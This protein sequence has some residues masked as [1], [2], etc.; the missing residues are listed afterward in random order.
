MKDKVF[1]DTN[2]VIYAYSTT[3]SNKQKTAKQ[4]IMTGNT[5]ISTQ[6]LQEMINTF[7]GKLKVDYDIVK[8]LLQECIENVN[9]LAI[10]SRLTIFL[11]CDVAKRYGFSFYDSLIIAA[12]LEN[13]CTILYSEDLQHNQVIE[14]RL[15][16]I[17]PFCLI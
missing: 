16:I 2:I 14:Q 17:N 15:R 7:C 5:I 6:V 1:L 9:H 10:N 4:L 3:D 12:A 13:N 8:Y 11:A